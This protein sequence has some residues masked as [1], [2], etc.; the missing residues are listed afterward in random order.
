MSMKWV[1][2]IVDPS[3]TLAS[4]LKKCGHHSV[5][6]P[7]RVKAL[8]QRQ[9]TRSDARFMDEH[10]EVG[11]EEEGDRIPVQGFEVEEAPLLLREF[12]LLIDEGQ[13]SYPPAS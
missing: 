5:T 2:H 3:T 1:E 11:I 12:D 4:F 6:K 7:Q 8:S 9:S 10:R 13:T